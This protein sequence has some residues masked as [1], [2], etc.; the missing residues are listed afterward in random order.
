MPSPPAVVLLSG[1][2]DSATT[3]AIARAQGFSCH[4]LSFR[5]GQRHAA[6]TRQRPTAV[7]RHLGAAE[8]RVV[9]IDLRAFGG[10]ALT[11]DLA[12]PKDRDDA[13]RGRGHPGH[14]RAGAQHDLPVLRAWRRPRCSA[15]PTS[16]SASTPSTTAAIP[17]AGP[18][19]SRPS[20]GMANLATQAGVE[21]RRMTIHAP[22]HRPDQGRDH[23]PGP[24]TR[25]RLRH[26]PELLRP[27]TGRRGL[28]PLRRLP[29]AARGVPRSSA[30]PIR[31]GTQ[32]R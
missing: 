7:A 10:S 18:S 24:R 5:Y 17:T 3:L 13:A 14:L 9:E 30:A 32:A 20:S 29:A 19:S 27:G 12:V 1:G 2:L 8:H 25:R 26:D 23:R 28:R 22:L 6:G 4:A 16:S 31:P 11:A 21:G 15:P